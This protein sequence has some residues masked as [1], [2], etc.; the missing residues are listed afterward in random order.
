VARAIRD[1]IDGKE[2]TYDFPTV[3]DGV[4]GM[5]FIATAIKSAGSEQKWTPFVV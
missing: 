2:G 5:A 3:E 4:E 1:Q